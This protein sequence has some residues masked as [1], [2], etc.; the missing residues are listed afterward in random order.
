MK[1]MTRVH[2]VFTHFIWNPLPA[3]L[4]RP[5]SRG[6]GLFLST[7]IS[8][9]VVLMTAKYY[10]LDEKY[11]SQ[12]ESISGQKRYKS[13]QDFFIRRYVETPKNLDSPIW[14]C[15][16]FICESGPT[17]KMHKTKVKGDYRHVRSIFG[18]A[19]Q[20]IPHDSFFINI[21][22]HN[23]NYHRFHAPTSGYVTRIEKIPG[24]LLFLRPWL[25]NFTTP[26]LPAFKNERFNIDILDERGE[27][28]F[29]SFVGGMGVGTI[30]FHP[31]I[32]VG[33]KLKI[34]DELGLFLL[35]STCCM[36]IPAHV[37]SLKPMQSINAFQK[38]PLQYSV[39]QKSTPTLNP[40]LENNL[41][42]SPS[43]T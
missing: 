43:M 25:Y 42:N 19:A 7:K 3:V 9:L 32:A 16:G 15:E 34:G 39:K 26:T 23:H 40:S 35:G 37:D 12:F 18:S 30:R 38:I 41:W 10:Q 31:G 14:P 24:K 20:D 13:F 1:W 2:W 36:A 29:L 21:F 27:K 22:L 17:E 11:F 5:L 33:K 6:W 4:Q 28:W 8:R